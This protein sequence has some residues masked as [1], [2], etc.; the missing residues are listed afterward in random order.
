V[1]FWNRHLLGHTCLRAAVCDA[2]EMRVRLAVQAE[3]DGAVWEFRKFVDSDL[4]PRV[5][6]V[7]ALGART[8]A[9]AELNQGVVTQVRWGKDLGD[10]EVRLSNLNPD[11]LQANRREFKDAGWTSAMAGGGEGG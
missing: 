1:P 9:S 7:V 6:E 2:D 3:V 10:V 11:W 4:V 5:G 8:G